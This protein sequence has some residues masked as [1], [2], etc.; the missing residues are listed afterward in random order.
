MCW[1]VYWRVSVTVDKCVVCRFVR[2]GIIPVTHAED[3]ADDDHY[4]RADK[5]HRTLLKRLYFNLRSLYLSECE[6]GYIRQGEMAL[7][8]IGLI[9]IESL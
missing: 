2:A 5:K 7:S 1:P 3:R 8:A 9:D 4:K 6:C